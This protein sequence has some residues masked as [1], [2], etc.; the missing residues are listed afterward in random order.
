M[1]LSVGRP[2]R[3]IAMSLPVWL[4]IIVNGLVSLARFMALPFLALYLHATLHYSVPLTGL[5]V[6][7]GALSTLVS[8]F[9]L[10]PLP[11]RFGRV[12]L[13]VGSTFVGAL[14]LMGYAVS[15]TLWAFIG[16]M[17]VQGMAYA[18]EGPAFSALL[19]DLTPEPERVRVFGYSYWAVNVG[20][21]I[22]PIIGAVIGAGHTPLPFLDAGLALMVIGA[23]LGVV[24]TRLQVDRLRPPRTSISSFASFRSGLTHP[25]L[26]VFLSAQF[27]GGLAYAQIDTNLA[28]Y[29]GLHTPDGTGLYAAMMAANAITVVALQP[30]IVR[31]QEHSALRTG[32]TVGA[33]VYTVASLLYIWAFTPVEW[34][35]THVLFS[36]GEVFQSP[37]MQVVVAK[38]APKEERAAYF[39]LQNVFFGLAFFLGPVLGGFALAGGGKAGLFGGMA[40]VNAVALILYYV[41][42]SRDRAFLKPAD[43]LDP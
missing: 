22:G 5:V 12:R 8:S 37:A 17:A 16:L 21:A 18:L 24:L 20:A 23:G 32:V 31:W 34:V 4:L 28:Q 35:G 33:V 1:P 6:G 30:V 10:G 39:T 15:H 3:G 19:T 7:L 9:V 41:G 36:V 26:L 29:V 25:V 13:L 40:L 43:A 38:V 14:S 27:A 11:D 42:M 2:A